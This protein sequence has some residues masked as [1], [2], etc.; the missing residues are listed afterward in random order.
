[1]PRENRNNDISR[2]RAALQELENGSE[3]GVP[4]LNLTFT[5]DT[6]GFA[7][8]VYRVRAKAFW[9]R[10][11]GGRRRESPGGLV[12]FCVH[13]CRSFRRRRLPLPRKTRRP[14]GSD[15][16]SGP[17]C[18]PGPSALGRSPLPASGR[19]E[20]IAGG[21]SRSAEQP[22]RR[23]SPLRHER[24]ASDEGYRQNPQSS[25]VGGR[26]G[27]TA[28]GGD[29]VN[30]GLPASTGCFSNVWRSFPEAFQF[31]RVN[32]NHDTRRSRFPVFRR[33]RTIRPFRPGLS[34]GRRGRA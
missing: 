9:R 6:P 11:S 13:I 18:P 16:Y 32:G 4:M 25:R 28:A 26:G 15:A 33:R 12:R 5:L 17:G 24:S 20:R 34:G 10:P 21:T 7:D 19:M 27:R 23:A 22:G 30:D 1:M 2:F 3:E 31:L 29:L 14:S 8:G